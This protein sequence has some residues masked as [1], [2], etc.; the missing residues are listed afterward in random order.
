MAVDITKANEAAMI[1]TSGPSGI[2]SALFSLRVLRSLWL[3]LSAFV[4]LLLLPFRGRKRMVSQATTSGSKEE[5]FDKMIERKGPMVRVPAKMVPRKNMVDNEV[6]ARR[7]LAIKRVLEDVD[8][9][10]TVREFSLFVTS[11]GDTMFTQSWTPVS[12][13]VRGLVFLLH[14]LNEHSG[15]YDD[16]AKKLNANGYKVYGIDWTG[17]VFSVHVLEIYSFLFLIIHRF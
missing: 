9:K 4:L 17:K 10:N 12:L 15:R 1:L 2:I 14:G 7:V 16:F 13:K 6:A 11:R 8:D 5:K 3:L